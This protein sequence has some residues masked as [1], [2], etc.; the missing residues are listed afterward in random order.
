MINMC[1][2]GTGEY[3]ED[4]FSGRQSAQRLP[5]GTSVEFKTH[6]AS[7]SNSLEANVFIDNCSSINFGLFEM[8]HKSQIYCVH[9]NWKMT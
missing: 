7:E 2:L 8:A 9:L 1:S 6:P 3:Q 5:L 4:S